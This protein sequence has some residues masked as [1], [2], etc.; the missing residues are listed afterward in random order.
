M[1]PF[2]VTMEVETEIKILWN[3]QCFRR[4]KRQ[5]LR[6]G[7]Y[8]TS[9]WIALTMLLFRNSTTVSFFFVAWELPSLHKRRRFRL[10]PFSICR[11]AVQNWSVFFYKFISL[12]LDDRP[13]RKRKGSNKNGNAIWKICNWLKILQ[14]SKLKTRN[15][16]QG[17]CQCSSWVRGLSAS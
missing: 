12:M 9:Y 17:Y 15:N 13:E 3:N 5:D 1:R 6:A 10:S 7:L 2:L 14:A 8:P 4:I 16:F 11:W